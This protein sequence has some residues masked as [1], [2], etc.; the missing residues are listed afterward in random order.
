MTSTWGCA[1]GV[2]WIIG[3]EG[4]GVAG[5]IVGARG[6]SGACW[7]YGGDITSWL[8]E[9]R[10]YYATLN[11]PRSTCHDR[12]ICLE[13]NT[14]RT[15][16]EGS[17]IPNSHFKCRGFLL[18]CRIRNTWIHLNYEI[19]IEVQKLHEMKHY[20]N[21]KKKERLNLIKASQNIILAQ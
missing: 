2:G 1:A 14:E 18:I 11:T 7:L 13:K 3:I 12:W 21:L 10:L 4:T 8:H 15:M 16:C 20:N 9:V 17:S 6:T 5:R 19:T